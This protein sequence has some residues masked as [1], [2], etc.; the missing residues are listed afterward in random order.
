MQDMQNA[1][2]RLRMPIHPVGWPFIWIFAGATVLGGSLLWSP[3]WIIGG[4]LTC[5]C[6]W[7]FRNP[8][9]YPPVAPGVVV[10]PADGVFEAV[11]E[12]LPPPEL[13]MP[14]TPMMRI[15][16]FMN[17]FNVHVNRIPVTG[18][19][20]G[21][22]YRPGRFF[23]ASLDKASEHNERQSIKMRS[24][25]GADIAVVQIAG[26]IARRIVC[27]L[28]KGQGLQ[29]GERFGI[30][31]FGSRVDVYLPTDSDLKVQEGQI[32]IGG[33]TVIAV[34]DKRFAGAAETISAET[35]SAETNGA[36]TA[37]KA[38]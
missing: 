10:S 12:A 8:D 21:L 17:V 13:D 4:I 15:S 30:I 25:G 35:P 36:E 37:G 11:V 34:L 14:D 31:R 33:E 32:A 23:D 9:R 5:W 29:L 20:N 2:R 22:A 26:L 3:L 24:S 38:E 28:A 1:L 16:I 18:T 27:N 6:T 7:F 19:V